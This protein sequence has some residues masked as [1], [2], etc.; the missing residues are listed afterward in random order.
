MKEIKEIVLTENDKHIL[1]SYASLLDGLA[2]YMGSAYEIVLH[3]LSDFK[4]SVIKIV[5]GEHTEREEGA[6]ITDLALNMLQKIYEDSETE[7]KCYFTENA[8][9]ELM[10]S[11]TIVIKGENKKPIGVLCIN[12]YLNTPM[13]DILK[14]FTPNDLIEENFTKNHLVEDSDKLVCNEI[15]MAV[16]QINENGNIT[17]SL[18]NREIIR[19]LENEGI[20]KIRDSINTV[21]EELNLSKN[22]IY[23]HLRNIRSEK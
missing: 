8:K 18:R 3:S 13:L 15:K 2:E 17:P 14:C 1:E 11:A 6:P 9:G 19:I 23:L 4:H 16:H 12:C 22:T 7:H 21:A 20:F 10:K 5:N